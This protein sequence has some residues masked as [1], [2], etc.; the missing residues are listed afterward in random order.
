[1]NETLLFIIFSMRVNEWLHP[2]ATA[3]VA[4]VAVLGSAL[5]LGNILVAPWKVK[6]SSRY[7]PKV[8]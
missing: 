6:V 8:K 7:F 4:R 3:V 5:A 1:M 2:R